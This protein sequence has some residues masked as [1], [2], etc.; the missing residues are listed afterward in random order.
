M[1]DET[2]F[3]DPKVPDITHTL[4]VEVEQVVEVVDMTSSQPLTDGLDLDIDLDSDV[5]QGIKPVP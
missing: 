3:Y 5:D 1:F 2:L 4:R